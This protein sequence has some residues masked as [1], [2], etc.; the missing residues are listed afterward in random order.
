MTIQ[1]P[2]L[3]NADVVPH[4]E[5][6]SHREI[7]RWV[8]KLLEA[9]GWKLHRTGVE[10]G[11]A[12]AMEQLRLYDTLSSLVAR[13][14]S[15]RA[16]AKA[17]KVIYLDTKTTRDNYPNWACEAVPFAVARSRVGAERRG[18]VAW[19]PNIDEPRVVL[20]DV[21]IEE[22]WL[23]PERIPIDEVLE[24][25][26]K[27]IPEA[28]VGVKSLGGGSRDPMLIIGKAAILHLPTLRDYVQAL[29]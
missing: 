19:W 28:S 14:T 29:G 24:F 18:F 25:I 20:P 12:E 23:D 15:D 16:Y 10:D 6:T 26:R 5:T 21:H 22:L 13:T 9:K 7:Q 1:P 2:K 3:T 8:D 11:R 17:G 27:H 4:P